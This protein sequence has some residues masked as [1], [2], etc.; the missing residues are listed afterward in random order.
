MTR[1]ITARMQFSYP[2]P[3]E[4]HQSVDRIQ[5]YSSVP[6]QYLVSI[7]TTPKRKL[8]MLVLSIMLWISWVK[9]PSITCRVFFQLIVVDIA[10]QH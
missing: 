10:I 8:P 6:V 9:R 5:F 1:R 7:I 2:V 4:N 3:L